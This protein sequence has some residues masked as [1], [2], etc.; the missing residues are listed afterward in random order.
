MRS[1]GRST[2]AIGIDI[3]GTEFKAV[4]GTP[5]GLIGE[6]LRKRSSGVQDA[7]RT[8]AE[9]TD[10]V[11]V[12]TGMA[13]EA[14]VSVHRL[15]LAVP[16]H[17]DPA[18]GCSNYSA[19]LGW[20][21]VPIGATLE[22]ALGLPVHVEHD[23]Y[24]G[25]LAEFTLGA[26]QGVS[27]G[28]FV[29]VGTGI[30]AAIF[31]EGRFWRGASGFV[32][33]IGHIRCHSDDT[34]CSCGRNGCVELFA[35]ARGLAQNYARLAGTDDSNPENTVEAKEIAARALH[36]DQ[37]AVEAWDICVSCLARTL[38]ALTL[39]TDVDMIVVGGGLSESGA[40]LLEPLATAVSKELA[41]LRAA[42]EI[43]RAT[44]GQL[45][46][47]HGAALHALVAG[48][49]K[50]RA[51]AS[52]PESVTA[53]SASA[54]ERTSAMFMLA[55][56]HRAS[57]ASEL[58]GQ[59]KVSS[60]QWQILTEAKT[61][62]AEAA[63]LAQDNF[64]HLGE[65]SVLVDP[66]CGTAAA[67]VASST[68]VPVALALE[69]SGQRRLE[70]LDETM[71]HTTIDTI[72]TPRWGKVLLRWN[73]GDPTDLKDANLNALNQARSLCDE[74]GLDL[75][76]E[77]IVAPTSSDLDTVGG[78]KARYLREVL[79]FLLPA[80]VGEL[81]RRFGLPDLWKL[82]GVASPATAA[83][84]AEAACVGGVVPP[85]LTLGAGADSEE[86]TRW[87]VAASRARGYSGFAIGRS[88][89]KAPIAAYLDGQFAREQA[90]QAIL[91]QFAEFIDNYVIATQIAPVEGR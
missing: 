24:A 47:A 68:G 82:Q 49:P 37:I 40:Q 10:L 52:R 65:V 55:F 51:I 23:V 48:L 75:L 43:R 62:I 77:L 32:G 58:F 16:G 29:P 56:D 54:P 34:P 13:A 83:L 84:V 5:D 6:P 63:G 4:L 39:T 3:G 60:E 87:F 53:T 45:A 80:A 9:I 28:A 30:A 26:G 59:E 73:P 21:D 50:V 66:E 90:Q 22:A 7:H 61:V 81:T 89:W 14:G 46:G 91:A 38:A 20:A 27:S 12:L 17:V 18:T 88:I 74:F 33:E 57:T 67:C 85:I 86:I 64:A 44:L 11:S 2:A 1:T 78:D 42:P 25:A 71:L 35:S 41:P 15:G 69:V 8:I 36:G 72:G 76:L 70:L 19:N 31:M 79:P